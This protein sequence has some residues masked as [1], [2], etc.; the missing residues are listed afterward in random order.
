MVSICV[1]KFVLC[2]TCFTCIEVGNDPAGVVV[3][4]QSIRDMRRS[5]LSQAAFEILVEHGMRGS[6][7]ERVAQ[8]AGVSKSVVLHHFKDKDALFEAV[9]RRANNV[10]RDSVIELLRHADTPFERIASVVVGNFAEPIF[11]QQVCQAWICLC[12]DVPYNTQSQRIQKV[13]HAR[14]RSNL[15]SALKFMDLG[16]DTLV[17]A[18]Q[19]R[20]TIDG[21]WLCASLRATPMEGREGIDYVN[22]AIVRFLGGGKAI[23]VQLLDASNKMEKIAEIILHSK[24][25]LQNTLNFKK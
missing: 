18:D 10:I 17:I 20:T 15:L 12:A 19:I 5:E 24:A 7:I 13:I 4:K 22:D 8:R 25:F 3:N 1:N 21:V 23:E 6:T 2:P 9:M 11:H 16:E 14:M